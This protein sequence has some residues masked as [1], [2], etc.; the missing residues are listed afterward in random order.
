[1]EQDVTR[2]Q[3]SFFLVVCLTVLL[4]LYLMDAEQQELLI[5]GYMRGSFQTYKDLI[6]VVFDFYRY[7]KWM[8]KSVTLRALDNDRWKGYLSQSS[9]NM[10]KFRVHLRSYYDAGVWRAEPVGAQYL[11]CHRML[12][13]GTRHARG[14]FIGMSINNSTNPQRAVVFE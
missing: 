9:E 10:D 3:Q 14:Y 12:R 4:L 5:F 8:S 2:E 7:F 6:L 1:M 11:L 13:N